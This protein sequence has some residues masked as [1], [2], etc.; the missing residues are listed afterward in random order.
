[1]CL[2]HLR[3]EKKRYFE[4][5]NEKDIKGNRKFWHTAKSKEKIY[6]N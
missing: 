3:K 2:T 4:N 5:L 6:F 1:M